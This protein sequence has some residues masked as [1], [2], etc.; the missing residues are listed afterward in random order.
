MKYNQT[1]NSLKL[2]GVYYTLEEL[3]E[4]ASIKLKKKLLPEWEKTIY[5]FIL[6]F[7]TSEDSITI[8]TSG[9]TGKPKEIQ[10]R[11]KLL[12]TSA[13]RTIRYFNITKHNNLLLCLPVDFIAGKMMIVR[14]LLSGAHLITVEPSSNPFIAFKDHIDFAAITPYQ[15]ANSI[16]T[17]A[18][19]K[20]PIKK[21]IIGGAGIADSVL[22]KVRKLPVEIYET[23]GMTETASHIS[24]R[25][26]NGDNPSNA[27][28]TLEDITISADDR[29]CLIIYDKE[30]PKGEIITN[31]LVKILSS[32]QF[33]WLGRIDNIINTGG[34]KISPEQIERK[35]EPFIPGNFFITSIPDEKLTEKIIL[36]LEGKKD[37]FAEKEL[38][39][40][41]ISVLA[42]YEIPK[43][44]FYLPVFSYSMNNKILRKE[45]LELLNK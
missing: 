24:L 45:T 4:F 23:Y 27:F 28:T 35:L 20:P 30:L 26:L 17:L 7:I 11:K 16:P 3:L 38:I 39:K 10:L 12:E 6:N 44:I 18:S 1:Y 13:L 19:G 34:I 22:K 42:K 15:L 36:L 43:N 21:I 37:T 29:G 25:R 9:S 14:A 8:V 31:D 32:D 2:D 40:N 33:V 41:S 5:N